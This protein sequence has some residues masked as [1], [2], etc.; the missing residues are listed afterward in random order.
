MTKRKSGRRKK[1]SEIF[2]SKEFEKDLNSPA[3]RVTAL[4]LGV[5]FIT[6]GF[7][8]INFFWDIRNATTA[9]GYVEQLNL[10]STNQFQDY[11]DGDVI[12]IRETIDHAN[13]NDDDDYT[14]ITFDSQ[15]D[16][17]FIVE[18]DHEDLEGK[19]VVL[20]MTV[21]SQSVGE[22]DDEYSYET[23]E[24]EDNN[25]VLDSG[26]LVRSLYYDA[27]FYGVVVLGLFVLLFGLIKY[28]D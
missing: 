19:C 14:T 22:G 28:R 27:V 23:I 6:L 10:G 20:S 15:D 21:T 4:V 3:L 13:Y 12:I 8:L 5:M 25:G 17:Q 9:E 7:L 26:T 24:E 18:G 2:D 11:S 1:K 16:Y